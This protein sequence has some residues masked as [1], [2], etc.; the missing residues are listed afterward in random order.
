ARVRVSAATPWATIRT[1]S[2]GTCSP[3]R[4]GGGNVGRHRERAR[5]PPFCPPSRGSERAAGRSR[6][7]RDAAA[8]A[9]GPHPPGQRA[10]PSE[11]DNG[12]DRVR[13]CVCAR[14]GVCQAAACV[15]VC[16]RVLCASATVL[17][18]CCRSAARSPL[19]LA[20]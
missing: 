8:A 4:G 9:A 18:G 14:G 6:S 5:A 13:Q 11:R 1:C 20:I 17:A 2:T 19:P 7:C 16:A 3:R 10:R 12:G 15:R